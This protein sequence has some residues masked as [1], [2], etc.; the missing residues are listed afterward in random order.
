MVLFR[1][2]WGVGV[3]HWAW[4]PTIYTAT[5]SWYST[6]VIRDA[7]ETASKLPGGT[8]PM[9]FGILAA[10]CLIVRF[11]RFI[12]SWLSLLV[13]LVAAVFGMLLAISEIPLLATYWPLTIGLL[14]VAW[15]IVAKT[16]R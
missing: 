3:L 2:S 1:Y 4:H 7:A 11:F 15:I 8:T 13:S 6:T 5:Q 16:R 9:K 10:A 12:P 14:V